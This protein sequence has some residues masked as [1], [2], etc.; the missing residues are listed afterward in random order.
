MIRFYQVEN[1]KSITI[2]NSLT[3]LA[4]CNG[5][6]LQLADDDTIKSIKKVRASLDTAFEWTKVIKRS[7]FLKSSEKNQIISKKG[8]S[9][10]QVKE[11]QCSKK[12]W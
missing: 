6:A 2:F 9:F 5:Q 7:M 3:D 4:Y 10:Q 12:L 1:I 8:R 11:R